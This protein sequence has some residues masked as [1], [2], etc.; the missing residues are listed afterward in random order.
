MCM[1]P[2]DIPWLCCA[3]MRMSDYLTPPCAAAPADQCRPVTLALLRY[4][5]TSD[6]VAPA[7]A[8][9]KHP[10]HAGCVQQPRLSSNMGAPLPLRF[11]ATMTGLMAWRRTP[12]ISNIRAGLGDGCYLRYWFVTRAPCA[13]AGLC[14]Q[15][16]GCLLPQEFPDDLG[17]T[18]A[19]VPAPSSNNSGCW[20]RTASWSLPPQPL[21]CTAHAA[22]RL[23][24]A[25][26][27]LR[28]FSL[29]HSL[30]IASLCLTLLLLRGPCRPSWPPSFISMAGL[31]QLARAFSCC[32]TIAEC[33]SSTF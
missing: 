20:H 7:T 2:G 21:C 24:G 25:V 26:C 22:L 31:D 4:R 17:K 12:A 29:K 5:T 6:H 23:A 10:P 3:D 18:V 15:H 14:L 19:A 8:D 30:C 32:M 33:A 1:R 11:P 16:T 13:P 28:C 9:L 27:C